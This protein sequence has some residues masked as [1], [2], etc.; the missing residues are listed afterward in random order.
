M[1]LPK[2]KRAIDRTAEGYNMI[3]DIW[4]HCVVNQKDSEEE[5]AYPFLNCSVPYSKRILNII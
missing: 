4:L 2:Q 1:I 5:S 3:C